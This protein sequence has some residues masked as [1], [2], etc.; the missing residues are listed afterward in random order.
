M[1]PQT[2]GRPKPPPRICPQ[3]GK[4]IKWTLVRAVLQQACQDR[5][6]HREEVPERSNR[7]HVLRSRPWAD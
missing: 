5:R 4:P 7:Q 6:P 2:S 1:K 3:C